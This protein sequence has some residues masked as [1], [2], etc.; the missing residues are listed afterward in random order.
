MTG[1]LFLATLAITAGLASTPA[2]AVPINPPFSTFE[3]G[4]TTGLGSAF[5]IAFHAD[6]QEAAIGFTRL[7]TSF[8]GTGPVSNDR[9]LLDY[10]PT[11]AVIPGIRAIVNNTVVQTGAPPAGSAD[12]GY[13]HYAL[14]VDNG[15]VNIYF[16]GSEVASGNVGLGYTNGA[17]LHLGE[18]PHDGGGSANEQF[19]GNYD[20]LLVLNRALSAMDIALLTTMAVS[21]VVTPVGG[22]L[23]IYYD[24]EGS[25]A[26]RFLADGAQNGIAHQNT[27]IDP[28]PT[29]ARLGRGAGL[30]GV[31]GEQTEVPAPATLLLLTTGLIG[32]MTRQRKP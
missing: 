19:L 14:T 31:A 21:D 17:N 20:E 23:A 2:Q 32:L 5:T 9:I 30:L 8:R 10:D 18:D 24:F 6:N 29:H 13:H 3:I 1:R 25:L 7:V 4:G 12:P 16:D 27:I 26:D 22:E 15:D 28:D 11:G